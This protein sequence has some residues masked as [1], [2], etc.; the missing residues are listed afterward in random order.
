MLTLTQRWR[1]SFTTL[2]NLA[3]LFDKSLAFPTVDR[4]CERGLPGSLGA[5]QSLVH[6]APSGPGGESRSGSRAGHGMGPS[7]STDQ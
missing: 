6:A 4:P 3:I 2:P 1:S 5:A 7:L